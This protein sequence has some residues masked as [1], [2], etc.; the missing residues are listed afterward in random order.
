MAVGAAAEE[1]AAHDWMHGPGGMRIGGGSGMTDPAP[2]A[3]PLIRLPAPSPRKRGEGRW[4]QRRRIPE[5]ALV[6]LVA[7]LICLLAP[8]AFAHASLIASVPEDGGVLYTAPTRYRLTF[9]EPVS[10]LA[11]RLVEPDGSALS[12]D[13][14]ELKDNTLEIAAP[15]ALG[16]GTYVLSW[17]VIS[18]DGHPVGGSVVFSIGAPS[19]ARPDV[20]E[21]VDWTVRAGLWTGKVLLYVGLFIGAGGAFA[22]AWLLEGA[23]H[24]R[25]VIFTALSLGLLGAAV[26]VGFQGLDA[27]DVEV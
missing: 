5:L 16:N 17:R 2:S 4:P 6:A 7:M 11:L 15:A 1:G 20:E 26:S 14:F 13:R 27:L 22:L 23:R 3:P 19:A 25:A 10:P 9:N 8:Q 12:L 24:G 18:E 21:P